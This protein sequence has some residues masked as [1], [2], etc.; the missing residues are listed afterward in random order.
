MTSAVCLVLEKSQ[1]V[2]ALPRNVSASEVF[3]LIS[4]PLKPVVKTISSDL[5]PFGTQ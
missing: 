4:K 3:R 5:G 2:L 1:K